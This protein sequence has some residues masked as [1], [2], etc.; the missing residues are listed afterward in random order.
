MF[1]ASGVVDF[2]LDLRFRAEVKDEADVDLGGSQIIYELSFVCTYDSFS[3]FYFKDDLSVYQDVRYIISYFFIFIINMDRHLLLYLESS[4][5][6]LNSKS[7]FINL[8]EETV[9]QGVVN[10]VKRID[11]FMG[12]SLVFIP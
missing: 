11:D 7:I 12:Q 10:L 4:S 2:A 6:Q 5:T 8:F 1:L 3:R 9:T